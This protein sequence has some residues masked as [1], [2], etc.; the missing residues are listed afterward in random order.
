MCLVGHMVPAGLHTNVGSSLPSYSMLV[1]GYYLGFC[2]A[3]ATFFWWFAGHSTSSYVCIIQTL[4]SVST[5]FFRLIS[6]GTRLVIFRSLHILRRKNRRPMASRWLPR[7]HIEH[8]WVCHGFARFRP[9]SNVGKPT[10]DRGL[11]VGWLWVHPGFTQDSPR[12]H[13]G[14]C[15]SLSLRFT[16]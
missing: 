2:N 1:F 6:S 11:I 3:C 8:A 15:E 10:A 7:N 13:P 12:I 5:L 4:S 16:M 14:K 9:A